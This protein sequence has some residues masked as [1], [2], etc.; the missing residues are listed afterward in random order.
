MSNNLT[1]CSPVFFSLP[2]DFVPIPNQIVNSIKENCTDYCYSEA[3]LQAVIKLAK[4]QKVSL[5]YKK[6]LDKY[7][8]LDYIIL[9]QGHFY[10]TLAKC[11][12]SE[13]MQLD[14]NNMPNNIVIHQKVEN[15]AMRPRKNKK[16]STKNFFGVDGIITLK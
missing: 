12:V 13:P 6:V 8:D 2:N 4:N 15:P 1:S 3:M 7:G 5:I 11:V 10:D 9:M 14:G 16:A